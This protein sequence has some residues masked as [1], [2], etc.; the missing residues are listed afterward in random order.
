MQAYRVTVAKTVSDIEAAQR[1]RH[2][3]Y[4]EEEGLLPLGVA[5]DPRESCARDYEEGTTHLL[6]RDGEEPVG[7]VRLLVPAGGLGLD[8][9]EKVDLRALQTPGARLGEVTRYCVLKSHRHT[10]VARALFE[11]LCSESARLGLTSWV[12]GANMSTDAP[13]DAALIHRALAAKGL[14]APHLEA[15]IRLVSAAKPR[16]SCPFY[17]EEQ[18]RC[19]DLARL[20]LPP[21]LALFSRRM[22]A[23]F[24]GSPVYDAYFNVFAMPLVAPVPGAI[25]RLQPAALSESESA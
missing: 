11:A 16:D 14:C 24:L 3:V 2:V 12:A 9:A 21:A 19:D 20:P 17:T 15:P 13:E 10:G 5:E 22:G 7:T 4:R 1:V 25:Y 6:V 8:L 23:R 18:R